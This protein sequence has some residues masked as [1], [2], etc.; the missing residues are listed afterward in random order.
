MIWKER[1]YI[2]QS[3]PIHLEWGPR[4]APGAEL[5]PKIMDAKESLDEI[6]P[7]DCVKLDVVGPYKLRPLQD[8]LRATI[9]WA[10]GLSRV[11]HRNGD[12]MAEDG[13]RGK[14]RCGHNRQSTRDHRSCH[15]GWLGDAS[16]CAFA[17]DKIVKKVCL[18]SEVLCCI[19]MD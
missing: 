2:H 19:R 14:I 11:M 1:G 15:V 5:L 13:E 3:R 6:R 12:V 7:R 10:G 17:F 4:V 8:R 16:R 9:G 18:S